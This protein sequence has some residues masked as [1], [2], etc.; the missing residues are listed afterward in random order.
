MDFGVDAHDDD[1]VKGVVAEDNKYGIYS[2]DVQNND[3]HDHDDG[4]DGD[5][6]CLTFYFFFFFLNKFKYFYFEA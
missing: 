3:V 1:G 2:V 5:C 6:L 4:D